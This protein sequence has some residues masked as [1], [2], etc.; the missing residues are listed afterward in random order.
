MV[1]LQTELEQVGDAVKEMFVAV[2]GIEA[3]NLSESENTNAAPVPPQSTF[4]EKLAV[5]QKTVTNYA[6][7][8]VSVIVLLALVLNTIIKIRIQHPR[9]VLNGFLMLLIIGAVLAI[10]QHLTLYNAQIF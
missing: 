5:S 4:L 1:V 9:L 2:K 7:I 8:F 6:F 3:D 10:N